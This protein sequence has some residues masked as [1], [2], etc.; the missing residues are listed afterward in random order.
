MIEINPILFLCSWVRNYLEPLSCKNWLILRTYTHFFSNW[1]LAWWGP[2]FTRS[3][4]GPWQ[5]SRMTY[6]QTN[7]TC[8][9]GDRWLIVVKLSRKTVKDMKCPTKMKCPTQKTNLNFG[10]YGRTSS[11]FAVKIKAGAGTKCYSFFESSIGS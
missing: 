4:R 10:I 7:L 5:V 2:S 8:P 1:F 3:P 6:I 9:R 11:K